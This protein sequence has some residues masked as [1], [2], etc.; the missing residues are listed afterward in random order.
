MRDKLESMKALVA[1]LL[2]EAKKQGASAAEASLSTGQGL[3]VNARLGEVETVEYHC[4]QG[5][6][7]TVYAGHKKGSASTTDLSR[8]A[9]KATVS[10]ACAIAKYTTEDEFSG[11]PDADRLATD[12][13]DLDVYHPWNITPEQAIESCIECEQVALTFDPRIDNSE[14]ANI[15]SYQGLRVMGNSLGFLQGYVSSSHSM[16]CS[17]IGKQGDSMQRDYWYTSARD[18]ADLESAQ[19]VG[20]KAAERTVKRLGARAISTRQCPVIYASEVASSLIGHLLG[21]ISGGSLYRKSSFLLDSLGQQI[22]PEFMH[23]HERPHLTKAMGSAW[24]DGEG[25][26]TQARDLVANGVL[27]SYVLSSYS[28]RKLGL[29]STGNA[30][31]VHNLCVDSGDLDLAGLLKTMG[32]GLLVTEFMGQGVNTLTGDYSRGAAG[33][34]IENGEISHAVEE[35]TIAGNLKDMFRNIVAIGNDVDLRR[36]I[37]TGSIMI[38]SMMLAG[39]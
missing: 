28:A 3:S 6:G 17:V 34:W 27:K 37:R 4:D 7:I 33:Y 5:L 16:S 30:G 15:S 12:A 19:A 21:A 31:G 38:E 29:E 20:H 25:V 10:A 8:E 14:G 26:A 23:I 1:D 2:D 24:Y 22:F 39:E 18:A 13:L 36:N 32:N 35:I 9:I 11:L